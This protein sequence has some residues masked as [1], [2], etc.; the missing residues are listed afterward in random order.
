[1]TVML[2]FIL[3]FLNYCLTVSAA[4]AFVAAAVTATAVGIAVVSTIVA[5][6]AVG[7]AVVSTIVASTA[8]GVVI[9]IA[10]VAS[11][12]VGIAVVCTVVTA[13]AIGAAAGAVGIGK[14]ACHLFCLLFLL[15]VYNMRTNIKGLQ[16]LILLL[17]FIYKI[18]FRMM[19]RTAIKN[20]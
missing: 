6:T 2:I 20:I 10:V 15:L 5:A 19:N 16:R 14:I 9:V 1:M 3:L 18:F 7:I 17:K 13:T 8:V 12:A 11:T 4:T